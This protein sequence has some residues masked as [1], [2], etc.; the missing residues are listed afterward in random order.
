MIPHGRKSDEKCYVEELARFAVVIKEFWVVDGIVLLFDT[1]RM[2]KVKLCFAFVDHS[3]C[4]HY[5]L[6]LAVRYIITY[7]TVKSLRKI[8]EVMCCHIKIIRILMVAVL[9]IL[10]DCRVARNTLFKHFL[11]TDRPQLSP[12]CSKNQ[13]SHVSSEISNLKR[14]RPRNLREQICNRRDQVVRASQGF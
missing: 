5:L 3:I 4:C 13:L 10:H 8:V 1:R 2:S 7:S 6:S 11:R 14:N 9:L 12:A